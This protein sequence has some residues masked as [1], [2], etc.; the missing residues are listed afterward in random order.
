VGDKPVAMGGRSHHIRLPR[1]R[2]SDTRKTRKFS[3]AANHAF[4]EEP[5]R[6]QVFPFFRTALLGVA[7]HSSRVQSW[8]HI[9]HERPNQ[10]ATTPATVRSSFRA[11]ITTLRCLRSGNSASGQA[12]HR[13]VR[14]R[15]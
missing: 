14:L 4:F 5:A 9:R 12:R 13:E 10:R 6:Q 1:S 15:Y 7:R 2:R 3:S 11:G 8:R